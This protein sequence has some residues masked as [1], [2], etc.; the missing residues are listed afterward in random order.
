MKSEI[1][2]RL[3]RTLILSLIALAIGAGVGL[4]Q[5]KFQNARVS[6]QGENTSQKPLPV[7]G[8]DIGGPFTL[9]DHAGQKVTEKTYEGDYKLIYFGFTYCPA[10]C[11]TELQ[12]VSRVMNA[13]E[14]DNP[15]IAQNIQPLFITVD[16]ERDTV[17]VMKDYVSLFHPKLIGLTGTQPQID[18][19][20]KS[21]RIFA[22]K[23]EDPDDPTGEDYTM[24]H[25]SYIYL[26]GP[27]NRLQS[28]YRMEDTPD[29]IYD[30]ILKHINADG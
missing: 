20:T 24:D 18:F 11:P 23:V 9:T 2:K 25:S 16:P 19:I 5:A 30:D 27:E 22:R 10:I 29:H 26:M 14:K 1:K 6:K 4:Y 7:A 12:K 21:Y 13:L 17:N 3:L 8:L 15:E 28:I